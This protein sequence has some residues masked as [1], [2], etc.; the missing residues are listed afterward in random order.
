MPQITKI[1][2]QK[3]NTE[4]FNVFLD[5]KYAFPISMEGLLE[6]KIK[7]KDEITDEKLREILNFDLYDKNLQKILAFITYRPRSK[8][9]VDAKLHSLLFGLDID[10]SVKSF[11]KER[12]IK[13][14]ISLNLYNDV[15][16]ASLY[17]ESSKNNPI[18]M[19]INKVRDFLYK[20]GVD[21]LQVED[22]LADYKEYEISGARREFLKKI[23]TSKIT[24]PLDYKN[25][26]KVSKFL[27]GKGY[28]WDAIN[29]VVDSD[30]EL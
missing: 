5:G 21:K 20:K 23:R 13:R 6:F 9:E 14:L 22:L 18:P 16:F 25:K 30:F 10:D 26:M 1:E 29:A 15:S 24:K 2:V 28:S 12:V 8:G 27:V 3:N 17:V 4:R 19:G 11:I 7:V